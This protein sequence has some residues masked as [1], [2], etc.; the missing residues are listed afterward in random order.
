[1]VLLYLGW[2]A[3]GPD[4]RRPSLSSSSGPAPPQP[5]LP[6]WPAAA[7]VKTYRGRPGI[8]REDQAFGFLEWGSGSYSLILIRVGVRVGDGVRRSENLSLAS[9]VERS[10][11]RLASR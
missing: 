1:M 9:E 10:E 2:Q 11:S 7:S 6:S 8:R 5:V 4:S 3:A